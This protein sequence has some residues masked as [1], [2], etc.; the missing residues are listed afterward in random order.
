STVQGG[1][2]GASVDA[3]V[4]APLVQDKLALRVVGNYNQFAGYVDNE[5]YGDKNINDGHSYGGRAL[6][7]FT[8]TD[9]L[10]IDLAAYYEK[11]ATDSPRWISETGK[12]H[13]SDGRSESGN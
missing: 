4:N 12:R 13:T 9:R 3:M 10:T 8:P 5:Y 2:L 7:R 6:L 1:S 11:V